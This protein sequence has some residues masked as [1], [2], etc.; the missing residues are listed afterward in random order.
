MGNHD[1]TCTQRT[2]R[3]RDRL[4]TQRLVAEKAARAARRI[5]LD[6]LRATKGLPPAKTVAQRSAEHR[7]RRA[8]VRTEQWYS[9]GFATRAEAKAF[10]NDHDPTA[11]NK[12]VEA[13]LDRTQDACHRWKLHFNKFVL[14]YGVPAART[15]RAIVDQILDERY[16]GD[17]DKL[18]QAMKEAEGSTDIELAAEAHPTENYQRRQTVFDLSQH[19]LGDGQ[20]LS[21]IR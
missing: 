11:T 7:A 14:T 2:R 4:K 17:L 13:L 19:R 12:D 18:E 6:A 3:R 8:L 9:A 5:E 1:Y 20:L 21:L 10:L 15:A 16:Q